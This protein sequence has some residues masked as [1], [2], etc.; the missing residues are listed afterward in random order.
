MRNAPAA[1]EEKKASFALRLRGI[2]YLLVGIKGL[3]QDTEV[4][5]VEWRRV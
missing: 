3:T 4:K 1:A 2:L 5:V